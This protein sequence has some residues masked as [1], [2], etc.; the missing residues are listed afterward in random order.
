MKIYIK[1]SIEDVNID[2]IKRN[3]FLYYGVLKT[4][5]NEFFNAY[6]SLLAEEDD[7]DDISVE[8]RGR[9]YDKYIGFANKCQEIADTLG[10]KSASHMSDYILIEE[11]HDIA[12]EVADNFPYDWRKFQDFAR[13][14]A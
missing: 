3:L 8:L 9:I 14:T 2:T 1:A 4:K 11:M 10:T 5:S 12:E 7:T 6:E 13:M